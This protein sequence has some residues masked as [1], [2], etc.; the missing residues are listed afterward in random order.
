[1]VVW[2]LP[3][4]CP[5]CWKDYGVRKGVNHLLTGR[6]E[7]DKQCPACHW[8]KV[9]SNIKSLQWLEGFIIFFSKVYTVSMY[10][11]C[12]EVIV[13]RKVSTFSQCRGRS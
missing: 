5:S 3:H 12:K 8:G 2:C 11:D 10:R 13:L 9:K 7:L 6:E 4:P 1:M